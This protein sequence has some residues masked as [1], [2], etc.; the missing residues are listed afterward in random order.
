MVVP[1]CAWLCVNYLNFNLV[2]IFCCIWCI[3]IRRTI[4]LITKFNHN[5]F[6][7]DFVHTITT[8]RIRWSFL[9]AIRTS[10]REGTFL[11]QTTHE[12]AEMIGLNGNRTLKIKL[13][14]QTY[15]IQLSHQN[16]F[17]H[18]ISKCDRSDCKKMI[19]PNFQSRNTSKKTYVNTNPIFAF[20]VFELE[21]TQ[22]QFLP[23]SLSGG[24]SGAVAPVGDLGSTLL[25]PD[26]GTFS[27]RPI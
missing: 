10:T 16:I 25:V 18:Q 17:K 5:S 27:S 26:R 11:A 2:W 13:K 7:N 12:L 21:A 6:K 23:P 20:F 19:C 9:I 24:L 3:F 15:A 8:L 4:K 22:P 14:H 1:M